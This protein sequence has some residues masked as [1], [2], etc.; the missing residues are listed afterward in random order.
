MYL[1]YEIDSSIETVPNVGLDDWISENFDVRRCRY[2]EAD[3][4]R[5]SKLEKT[6]S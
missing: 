4:S 1:H 3:T 5:V 2:V 6:G